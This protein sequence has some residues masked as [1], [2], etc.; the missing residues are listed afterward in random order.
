MPRDTESPFDGDSTRARLKRIEEELGEIVDLA[1][2]HERLRN[3]VNTLHEVLVGGPTM[4]GGL[5]RK[6]DQ[7]SRQLSDYILIQRTQKDDEITRLQRSAR[8]NKAITTICAV[9]VVML[10]MYQ[11]FG[12]V[13]HR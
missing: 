8:W 10:T 2:D 7:V 5:R 11:I 13:P 6:M 9:A 12:A 1:E 4:D 3:E